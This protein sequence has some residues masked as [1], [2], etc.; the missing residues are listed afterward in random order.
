MLAIYNLSF[1]REL[2][3]KIKT[4]KV[5][6]INIVLLLTQGFVIPTVSMQLT[7]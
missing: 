7:S 3:Q 6:K 1:V 4:K 5:D 2:I